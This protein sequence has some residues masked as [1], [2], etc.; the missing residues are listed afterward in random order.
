MRNLLN[1]YR[2]LRVT[3]TPAAQAFVLAVWLL[4][5]APPQLAHAAKTTGIGMTISIDDAD[6]TVRAI[7]PNITNATFNTSRGVQDV[8][9]LG[10]SAMERL[11]LLNDF[12]LTVTAVFDPASG[13]TMFTVFSTPADN[14]TRTVT[15][16]VG[17]KTLTAECIM[18]DV[19]WSRNADGSFTASA[20]F[21]LANGTAAAW[22]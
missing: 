8:T 20:T 21:Q 10:S 18:T 2:L 14:D 3:R 5:A 19:S 17:G 4:F 15:I 7:G 11:L 6:G 22:S 9:G 12:N 1:M 13:A 16:V